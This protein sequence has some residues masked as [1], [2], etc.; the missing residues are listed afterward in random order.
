MTLLFNSNCCLWSQSDVLYTFWKSHY[1]IVL[2][3]VIFYCVL[4]LVTNKK[5]YRI[6]EMLPHFRN[7]KKM[8]PIL[9]FSLKIM[10]KLVLP[11]I[12]RQSPACILIYQNYLHVPRFSRTV[13]ILVVLKIRTNFSNAV[14]PSSR[15][16]YFS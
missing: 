9:P 8:Y 15:V 2:H 3:F 6:L 7:A 14:P 11:S 13:E 4:Y 10:R 5:M 16:V 12:R 1:W